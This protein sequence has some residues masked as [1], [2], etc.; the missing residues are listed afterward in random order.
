MLLLRWI[1]DIKKSV[2]ERSYQCALPEAFWL[3]VA[4]AGERFGPA[5]SNRVNLRLGPV[6]EAV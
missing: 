6:P 3:I 4:L 5:S 1:E 2:L